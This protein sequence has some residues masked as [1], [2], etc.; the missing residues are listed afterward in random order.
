MQTLRRESTH[1]SPHKLPTRSTLEHSKIPTKCPQKPVANRACSNRTNVITLKSGHQYSRP[2]GGEA[3]RTQS[4]HPM[5][6]FAVKTNAKKQSEAPTKRSLHK[7]THRLTHSLTALQTIRVDTV[8]G[9]HIPI[10]SSNT[11]S[12]WVRACSRRLVV[13]Q[14]TL[15]I[16]NTMEEHWQ[17]GG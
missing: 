4:Q 9:H 12:E 11:V 8:K 1:S 16:P 5:P 14:W 7:H 6:E 13:K 10:S 17:C 15:P 2:M 3:H